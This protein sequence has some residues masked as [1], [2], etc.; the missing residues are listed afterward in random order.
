MQHFVFRDRYFIYWLVHADYSISMCSTT[1]FMGIMHIEALRAS[2]NSDDSTSRNGDGV[3]FLKFGWRYISG[4]NPVLCPHLNNPNLETPF[5][6]TMNRHVSENTT[7]IA[8]FTIL[9]NPKMDKI[10]RPIM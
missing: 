6:L 2:S 9:N 5:R 3:I 1:A 8:T 7:I 4:L 10:T